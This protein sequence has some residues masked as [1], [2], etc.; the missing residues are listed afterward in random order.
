MGNSFLKSQ[1]WHTYKYLGGFVEVGEIKDRICI[2][3]RNDKRQGDFLIL[4]Q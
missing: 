1:H 2:P 3:I 4:L